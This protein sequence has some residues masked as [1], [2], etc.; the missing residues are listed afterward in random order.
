APV[1]PATVAAVIDDSHSNLN[2]DGVAI[3]T[4]NKVMINRSVLTGNRTAGV[5]SDSGGQLSVDN[6]VISSN[7]T[8]VD[9]AAGATVRLS[10]NNIAF[11]TT[12]ISGAT[13]TFG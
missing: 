8:G 6:S 11:N 1:S 10:N 2:A 4:G 13:F 12:G 7:I 9:A 3:T 5:H